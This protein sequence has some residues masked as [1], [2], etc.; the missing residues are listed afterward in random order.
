MTLLAKPQLI[1]LA[2]TDEARG[3]V[4]LAAKEGTPSLAAIATATTLARAFSSWVDAKI[5]TCTET[6]LLAE[7]AFA[8]EIS[9]AGRIKP[10][11][12]S[13]LRGGQTTIKFDTQRAI[14]R[15]LQEAGVRHTVSFAHSSFERALVDACEEQGPWN[16][17]VLADSIRPREGPWLTRLLNDI[18]GATGIVAVGPALAADPGDVVVLVDDV[19]RLPQIMRAAERFA[20][21]A[22]IAGDPRPL[23]VRLL[24]AA[25]STT[26]MSELEGLVRLVLPDIAASMNCPVDLIETRSNH[27]TPAE[28]AEVIRRLKTTLV[29][30]RAGGHIWPPSGHAPDLLSVLRSPLLLVK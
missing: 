11:C 14:E 20:I 16:I 30:A 15:A 7:H 5:V 22:A 23:R 28:I 29:I 1:H 17:V 26:G 9:H 10:L 6:Q 4:V 27:G 19:D 25:D 18:S 24:L 13:Q 2:A 12:V 3:R 21:A 8:R